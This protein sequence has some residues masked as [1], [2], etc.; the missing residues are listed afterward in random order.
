MSRPNR[1]SIVTA[2]ISC[3][4]TLEISQATST[5][6]LHSSLSLPLGT[7]YALLGGTILHLHQSE[8]CEDAAVDASEVARIHLD[9]KGWN[10]ARKGKGVG[11]IVVERAAV[12]ARK[13]SS[14]GLSMLAES[15]NEKETSRMGFGD[16]LAL[17]MGKR[18]KSISNV[19]AILLPEPLD[20]ATFEPLLLRARSSSEA[21]KWVVA[22]NNSFAALA[23]LLSPLPSPTN[24]PNSMSLPGGLSSFA[25]FHGA[26]SSRPS[27]RPQTSQSL[28]SSGIPPAFNAGRRPSFLDRPPPSPRSYVTL[29]AASPPKKRDDNSENGPLS[30]NALGPSDV[31]AWIQ[32]VRTSAATAAPRA[33][34]VPTMPAKRSPSIV[35]QRRSSLSILTTTKLVEEPSELEV[36][37]AGGSKSGKFL[38]FLGGR[39][40]SKKES[41]ALLSPTLSDGPARPFTPMDPPPRHLFPPKVYADA[42]RSTSTTSLSSSFSES[43]SSSNVLPLTPEFPDS[44]SFA[45]KSQPSTL[46]SLSPRP[47]LLFDSSPIRGG[48]RGLSPA[49]RDSSHTRFSSGLSGA[50]STPTTEVTSPSEDYSHEANFFDAEDSPVPRERREAWRSTFG[51]RVLSSNDLASGRQRDALM[52]NSVEGLREKGREYIIKPSELISHMKDEEDDYWDNERSLSTRRSNGVMRTSPSSGSLGGL[53]PT[54]SRIAASRQGRGAPG[55]PSKLTAEN[56]GGSIP[57]IAPRGPE[58]TPRARARQTSFGGVGAVMEEDGTGTGTGG[59]GTTPTTNRKFL[60]V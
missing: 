19:A 20:L 13:R 6:I 47:S 39:R 50:S 17:R 58:S 32:Q 23:E 28:L 36:K 40:G 55:T 52:S 37:S 38:G 35:E 15:T 3:Q 2:S 30:P 51:R 22:I 21:D 1:P 18:T 27:R 57:G 16:R 14:P 49:P 44:T 42:R 45:V 12:V 41:S 9:E 33:D 10:V 60:T 25:N 24:L 26:S 31:P 7:F 46:A 4:G 5:R 48:R 53:S 59:G 34:S 29:T 11:E 54:P 43:T 8:T 56:N